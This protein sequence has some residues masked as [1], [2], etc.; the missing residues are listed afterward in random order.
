[1]SEEQLILVLYSVSQL[2]Y[3]VVMA[4]EAVF[5]FTYKAFVFGDIDLDD[6]HCRSEKMNTQ[7]T[8]ENFLP[9]RLLC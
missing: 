7:I 6:L 2:N 4:L 1:M 9:R 5:G 3:S 8:L